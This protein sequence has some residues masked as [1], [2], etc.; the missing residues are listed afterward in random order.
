MSEAEK[1]KQSHPHLYYT[2]L[3]YKDRHID[4]FKNMYPF[5]GLNDLNHREICEFI[6]YCLNKR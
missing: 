1:I 2:L 4:Y 3:E 6:L 5:K